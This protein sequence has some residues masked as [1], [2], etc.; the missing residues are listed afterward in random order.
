MAATNRT[1][2]R[3]VEQMNM[4]ILETSFYRYYINK[5]A[6]SLNNLKVL[7]FFVRIGLVVGG[8][9][10][11][12]IV[13]GSLTDTF[14][15]VVNTIYQVLETQIGKDLFRITLFI[16]T[17]VILTLL[18]TGVYKIMKWYFTLFAPGI[19]VS[20]AYLLKKIQAH[21]ISG[22]FYCGSSIIKV[23]RLSDQH[24]V[25]SRSVSKRAEKETND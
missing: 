14:T 1:L 7:S 19:V 13:L 6:D 3:E 4:Y 21:E 5:E 24:I 18:L 9:V 2:G 12:A 20:D 16:T 8:A 10:L 22:S 17:L 25:F 23:E 11:S 15:E